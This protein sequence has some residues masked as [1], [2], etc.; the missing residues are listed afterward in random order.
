MI[1]WAIN[2]GGRN[3]NKN[4]NSAQMN[5]GSYLWNGHIW[6]Y[7]LD[8]DQPIKLQWLKIWIFRLII[9]WLNCAYTYVAQSNKWNYYLTS[10][11]YQR[12]WLDSHTV[13]INTYSDRE[14]EYSLDDYYAKYLLREHLSDIN[15]YSIWVKING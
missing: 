11:L 4:S 5:N 8:C 6:I 14:V 1:G 13:A 9:V 12:F 7:F 3:I 2:I 15:L 10:L